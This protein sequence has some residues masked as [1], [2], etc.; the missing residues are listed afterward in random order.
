MPD[1]VIL[2]SS[3]WDHPS[4]GGGRSSQQYALAALRRGWRV[5]FFQRDRKNLLTPLAEMQPGPGTIVMCDVPFVD[6]YYDLFMELKAAG[7]AT[8]YRI[9]DNWHLTPRDDYSEEQ[10][11]AFL[12]AADVV[13]CSSPLNIER[14]LEVRP[15]LFLLRNGMNLEASWNWQGECPADL[16]PG[17]PTVALVASFWDPQWFDWLALVHAAK[18]C[19][20]MSIN[21]FGDRERIAGFHPVPDNIHLLGVHYHTE[22]P[23]YLHYCDVGIMPYNYERTRYNNPLKILDYLSNGLP[24]VCCPNI[25]VA[26]YPYLYFYRE[27]QEF[28]DK[29]HLAVSTDID[30]DFLYR[31]LQ[32]HTWDAGFECLVERM[33]P[34]LS[35]AGRSKA[36]GDESST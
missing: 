31:F 14:F 15:D 12:K 29:I 3:L 1:F 4:S 11:I 24:A 7:C 13:V 8:V 35:G 36:K 27:P 26:D 6:Y 30:R 22:L 2:G 5:S 17:E 21:V 33:R 25:S 9:I 32:H 20:R 18:S 23:A 28:L 19:P 16:V 34:F 10:E